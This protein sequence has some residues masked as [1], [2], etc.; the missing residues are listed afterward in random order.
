VIELYN[1]L[2]QI[3]TK[4]IEDEWNEENFDLIKKK[5]LEKPKA[6]RKNTRKRLFNLINQLCKD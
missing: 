6:K 5:L 2:F 1:Y 4:L 3:P